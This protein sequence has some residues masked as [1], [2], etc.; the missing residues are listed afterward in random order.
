MDKEFTNITTVSAS[1]FL[2]ALPQLPNFQDHKEKNYVTD[3]DFLRMIG[4]YPRQGTYLG[5]VGGAEN[6][7]SFRGFG[8]T[9]Q[10]REGITSK[11][12]KVTWD[13]NPKFGSGISRAV[14]PDGTVWI[15]CFIGWSMRTW[16]C[17]KDIE[18]AYKKAAQEAQEARKAYLFASKGTKVYTKFPGYYFWW[19]WICRDGETY[20]SGEP[21]CSYA[22]FWESGVEYKENEVPWKKGT[23]LEEMF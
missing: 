22:A 2:S 4:G 14:A 6:H 11:G 21:I 9:S 1:E 16:F 23:V 17:K 12:W 5:T 8:A 13:D 15:A 19:G 10:V 20:E 7:D 3:E 18:E